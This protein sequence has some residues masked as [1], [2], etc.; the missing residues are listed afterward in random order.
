M[1]QA[2]LEN[3]D[4]KMILCSNP[5]CETSVERRLVEDHVM[6]T[7]QWRTVHCGYCDEKYAKCD[8]EVGRKAH[9]SPIIIRKEQHFIRNNDVQSDRVNWVVMCQRFTVNV[10]KNPL[11]KHPR[12][13]FRLSPC[14]SLFR[15]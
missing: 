15:I 6:N 1:F 2:H 13:A 10:I 9:R 14:H 11:Q 12:F 3:C 8:E 5:H 7:C 4:C